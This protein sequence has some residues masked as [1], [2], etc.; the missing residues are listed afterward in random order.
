[1]NTIRVIDNYLPSFK[2]LHI[3]HVPD[4]S[5]KSNSYLPYVSS[6]SSSSSYVTSDSHSQNYVVQCTGLPYCLTST[7]KNYTSSSRHSDYVY[8]Y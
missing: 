6:Y 8:T 1:M 3:S 5:L 7:G 4:L 2:D